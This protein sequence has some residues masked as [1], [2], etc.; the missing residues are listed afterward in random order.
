VALPRLASRSAVEQLQATLAARSDQ[1]EWR[2]RLELDVLAAYSVRFRD[3]R[4]RR[5]Q[6]LRLPR[7]V[8]LLRGG[9][10][11]E[12]SEHVRHG[13]RAD[14]GNEEGAG[15][16]AAACG[17]LPSPDNRH[18]DNARMTK[19]VI[20]PGVAIRM[21]GEKLEIPAEH[22]LLAPT[23]FRSQVLATLHETVHR[24]DLS[25]PEARTLLDRIGGMPIRLLGDGVLRRRAWAIAEQ[26][27]WASTF[28]A[29]YLALTQLQADA[30]VTLDTDLARRAEGVVTVAPYD[31]L[32]AR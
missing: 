9:R 19:F 14:R 20:D 29:E 25:A 3:G 15:N 8:E 7:R 5:A 23:L 10:S 18:A 2:A 31:A 26:L 12:A 24:G 32:E 13:A 30:F 16:N 17:F 1:D 28:D 6:G 21:A 4:G 27:R 11:G 22:R